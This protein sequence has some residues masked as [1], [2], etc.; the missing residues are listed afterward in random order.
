VEGIGLDA[1]EHR[2][3]A[4]MI[5]HSSQ[6]NAECQCVF[7]RGAEQALIIGMCCMLYCCH[8][9]VTNNDPLYLLATKEIKRGDQIFIDYSKN[10]WRKS[11]LKN[12]KM[13]DLQKL[14]P[15][16]SLK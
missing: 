5:N 12:T 15:A 13:E 4:G 9:G 1:R 10:Y 16:L 6:P 3:L 7:D 8:F 11:T 14:F 2:N